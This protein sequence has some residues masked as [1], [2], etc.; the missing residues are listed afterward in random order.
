MRIRDTNANIRAT[1]RAG[2][3]VSRSPTFSCMTAS[4]LMSITTFGAVP[5]SS[6]HRSRRFLPFALLVA[7][8]LSCASSSSVVI[9]PSASSFCRLRSCSSR[10]RAWE[11]MMCVCV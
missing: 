3:G 10:S 9:L 8:A 4:Q 7:A 11:M 6:A 5:I 2:C 1:K